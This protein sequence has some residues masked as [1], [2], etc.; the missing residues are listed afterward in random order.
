[1]IKF[2]WT[3]ALTVFVQCTLSVRVWCNVRVVVPGANSIHNAIAAAETGDTLKIKPGTYKEHD[4][5]IQK[6]LT[7]VG[8]Q[9]P[10]VDADNKF[11]AFIIGADGVVIRGIQVQNVGQSSMTDMSGIRIVNAKFVTVTG[12]RLINTTFAIY[13]QN[14]SEC[15]VASNFIRSD[16][17]NDVTGGNGVHAW[18]SNKLL[19][20]GN[21]IS[22]HR[23][24][25][26]FEFVTDSKITGNVSHGNLRYGLH[27]M[28]S[29]GDI[30][31][32]NTFKENGAGV[33][34]MYSHD[35]TMTNNVFLH[36]WGEA[37]YGIL[38]KE[39]TDSKIDNN[40]FTKNTVGIHME[41]TTR[42]E[43]ERNL[44]ADN[45]WALRVQASCTGSNFF[46][47]NFLGNSF[48]VTTNGTLML[49]HFRHNFWDKYDGYDLD[50]DGVGDVPYYPVTVYSV[51]AERIPTAM[52][53][54]HS[55]LTNVMD[56][57]EKVL[58]TIIPDQLKDD[59]PAMKKIRL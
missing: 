14:A 23:D 41:G 7:I 11:Q 57:V 51:I 39:I 19:I 20:E 6:K 48:D 49:N 43:V 33:A 9:F 53:L 56:E 28:F 44:F 26:Y 25:I 45:G 8:E 24:G 12:N 37:S 31:S 59:H 10:I 13:L 35:V 47:N 22:G 46:D 15:V 50:K 55:I 16:A 38:L 4:L 36:N 1:M 21:D 29:H 17:L 32:K 2:T 18:K 54:Y 5:V 52:I 42:V 27:F 3:I 30:Y 40:Q 34:V 58:P